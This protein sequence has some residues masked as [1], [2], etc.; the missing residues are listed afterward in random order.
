MQASQPARAGRSSRATRT[1]HHSRGRRSGPSVGRRG[2]PTHQRDGSALVSTESNRAAASPGRDRSSGRPRLDAPGDG[3]ADRDSR[4]ELLAREI[5]HANLGPGD[6]G[7]G[8]RLERER[9]TTNA[10]VLANPAYPFLDERFLFEAA[11]RQFGHRVTLL[12]D[13]PPIDPGAYEE[14]TV[15]IV[16]CETEAG[17]LA[18]HTALT[19][20]LR[21]QPDALPISP[22][23][24]G[25]RP[26]GYRLSPEPGQI[27]YHLL[28]VAGRQAVEL[29][30]TGRIEVVTV[31]RAARLLG[32]VVTN[33]RTFELRFDGLSPEPIAEIGQA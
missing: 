2:Q 14:V 12:N 1:R 30:A 7:P 26:R 20:F 5:A 23:P 10:E 8:Y 28:T 16:R 29:I 3:A 24:V 21:S 11:R 19:G 6:L 13:S 22:G 31:Q 4:Q 25:S 15:F 18:Y 33:L 27:E 32:T 17:A 9:L